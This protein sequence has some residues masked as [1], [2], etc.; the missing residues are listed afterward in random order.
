MPKK[1]GKTP[2]RSEP[3][4]VERKF[5]KN[6]FDH[7]DR[8]AEDVPMKATRSVG[9]SRP[10]VSF[11]KQRFMNRE[12]SET[13]KVAFLQK[14]L[15]EDC[16]MS[17]GSNNNGPE[18]VMQHGRGRGIPRGRNSQLAQGRGIRLRQNDP[19]VIPQNDTIW[20]ST[21]TQSYRITIPYGQRYERTFITNKLLSLI[22]P[23]TFVP[24]MWRPTE[25]AV[26]FYV[27]DQK[28]ANKLRTC[29]RK[30]IVDEGFKLAVRVDP[31]F[32]HYNIDQKMRDSMKQAMAKRYVQ[33]TNALDLARFHHDPDLVEDY[34]CALS[35]PSILIAALDIVTSVIPNL[36]ALNLDHNQLYSFEKLIL[37]MK[38]LTNMKILYLGD[39]KIRELNQLNPLKELQLEELRLAGNPVCDKYK[40]RHDEYISDIRGKFPKLLRLD[41]QELPR[42][43]GFDVENEGT[44]LPPTQRMFVA[45]AKAQEIA[46]QF[47]QQYF[48]I[49]DS[50]NRQP[51]LD[52]YHEQASFSLTLSQ[53]YNSNK[54]NAYHADNRNLKRVTDAVRRRK[55][56]KVGRLPV[57]SYISEMPRTR[58]D[59]NSFT[60]DIGLVTDA[61]MIITVAGLFKEPE[62]KDEPLR[63]FNRT[64]VIVPEGSGYCIRNEQ[65]HLTSPTQMQEKQALQPRP[66][67]QVAAPAVVDTAA[68]G[69]SSAP[70][71]SPLTDEV[72]QQMTI[73]LSQHTNMNLEWS[74]KCLKEVNWNFDVALNAFQEFFKLGRIPPEAFKK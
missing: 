43:I 23:E 29:D 55:L 24:I 62:T 32:P 25:T 15:D 54:F 11:K 1:S 12:R 17:A 65:L 68:P 20:Y 53:S 7:D 9:G 39:N 6:Y 19:K 51:L 4:N 64:F 61:M 40:T 31:G 44:K 58:H 36:E 46:S 30:I 57:V 35:R 18:V 16:P 60:M 28:V 45:N 42:P 52:A 5:T 21:K 26:V 69:S 14:I 10:R 41:G 13:F 3:T 50:D 67:M 37:M 49:F 59:L 74:L 70:T 72:R 27:D 56:L 66:V 71:S 22:A 47:L 38:K 33:E 48:L 2:W 8:T 63:F 34:Y 73:T